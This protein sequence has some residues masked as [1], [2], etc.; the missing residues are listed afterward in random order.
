MTRDEFLNVVYDELVSDPD[1][2]RANRII[3]AAD[4]Y[5]EEY[6]ESMKTELEEMS[7]AQPDNQVNLCDSCKYTYPE[8]PSAVTDVIFGTGKGNDNICACNKYEPSAQPE[9]RWIPVS[10]RLPEEPGEYH[11]TN[12]LGHVVRYVFNDTASSKEYWRR[13]A[14]AWMPL[15][16][17]YKEESREDEKFDDELGGC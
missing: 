7:S 11:V 17:P 10:K 16:E 13:C 12:H 3:D 8:C 6:T 9:Q 1:N 4:E 2:N 5:A 15:P 14:I